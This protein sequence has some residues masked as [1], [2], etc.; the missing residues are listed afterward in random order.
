MYKIDQISSNAIQTQKITLPDATTFDITI[1]FVPLQ[2]G[3]FIDS[4]AYGDFTLE[5]Y[6]IVTSPNILN[7]FIN[8]LPFGLACFTSNNQEPTQQE[9]FSS[10]YA[11]LY[12][13]TA[14]E[15]IEWQDILRGQV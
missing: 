14:A 4:L 7:Q 15:V 12:I 2:F 6:R 11:N 3:W 5:G 8:R 10:G 9:D 1:R 13:L